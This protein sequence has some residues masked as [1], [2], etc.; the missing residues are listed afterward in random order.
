MIDIINGLVN[1][2]KRQGLGVIPFSDGATAFREDDKLVSGYLIFFDC[3]ANNL[4]RDTVTVNICRVPLEA[5][6]ECGAHSTEVSTYCIE[7]SVIGS[8]E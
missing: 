5:G 2:L 3:L 6:L 7:T 8:L 1:V 4:F